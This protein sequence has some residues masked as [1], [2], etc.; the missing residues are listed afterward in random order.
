MKYLTAIVLCAILLS[1]TAFNASAQS[2]QSKYTRKDV[3]EYIQAVEAELKR[4]GQ[5]ERALG[6]EIIRLDEDIEA[7]VNSIMKIL[8]S[9]SDSPDSRSR[10]LGMKKDAIEGLQKSIEYYGRERNKRAKDMSA[11]YSKFTEG[12]LQ[13]DVDKLNERI[14]KR[15]EQIVDLT[16]SFTQHKD[17]SRY[18]VYRNNVRH[19][20]HTPDQRRNEKTVSD[21]VREKS[22]IVDEIRDAMKA[23]EKKNTYL[24]S[25]LKRT[26]NKKTQKTMKAEIESNRELIKTRRKQMDDLLSGAAK[27]TKEATR[28]GA[29]EMNEL[30]DEI[31][32]EISTDFK[33][34]QQLVR[35]R[36]SARRLL[37]PWKD[38]LANAKAALKKLPPAE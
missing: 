11:T 17:Y 12:D 27:K 33:K 34:I 3:T 5:R 35:D 9:T 7:R 36:D 1:S 25:T 13:H 37:K 32:T 20:S 26:Y 4:R 16:Q 14:D 18:N 22:R 23:L 38:R 15:I 30:F 29:F 2:K 10:L 28:T 24:Q 31:T 8:T 19:D 21:G 6:E